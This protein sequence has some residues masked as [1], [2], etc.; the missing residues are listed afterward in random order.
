MGPLRARQGAGTRTAG[1]H[2]LARLRRTACCGPRL[3]RPRRPRRRRTDAAGAGHEAAVL[4]VTTSSLLVRHIGRLTTWHGP[5]V[6]DAALLARDGR[7]A[8]TGADRDVP[9]DAGD[10]PELDAAGAAVLPGF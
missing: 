2:L 9:L 7:V 3:R 1:A 6:T 10:V 5:V 8:W 4:A